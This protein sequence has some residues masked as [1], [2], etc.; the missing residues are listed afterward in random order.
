MSLY[1][2]FK[3]EAIADEVCQLTVRFHLISL[4]GEMMYC[5]YAPHHKSF[6]HLGPLAYEWQLG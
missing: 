6:T 2:R 3:E 4:N 1:S 5:V